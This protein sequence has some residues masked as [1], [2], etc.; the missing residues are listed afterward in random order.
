MSCW[1]GCDRPSSPSRL[2]SCS[3]SRALA[4]RPRH[5]ARAPRRASSRAANKATRDRARHR[6][7]RV[8]IQPSRARRSPA[9]MHSRL[10]SS[11]R[12][13]MPE[14]ASHR[15]PIRRCL[16]CDGARSWLRRPGRGPS[17]ASFDTA[18]ASTARTWLRAPIEPSRPR[19]SRAGRPRPSTSITGEI[20]VHL[21]K[22]AVTTRRWSGAAAPRSA[23]QS[24][25]AA[26]VAHL[27]AA[28]GSTGSA[29]THRRATGEA[30]HH[31]DGR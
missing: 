12:T 27:V 9:R 23:A 3:C 18:R 6:L 1:R 19:S 28:S 13:I 4:P 16:R 7:E 22:C 14:P 17:G 25:A 21:D 8:P 2:R 31:T 10:R 29:T 15:G 11:T 20:A 5:Q 24:R 26:A 30:R